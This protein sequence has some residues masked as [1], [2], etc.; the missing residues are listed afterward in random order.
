VGLSWSK[1]VLRCKSRL[2]AIARSC[3]LGRE[4]WYKKYREAKQVEEELRQVIANCED[5]CRQLE[6]KNQDL[7]DQVSDLRAKVTE[8]YQIQL[9]LGDVPSGQQYGANLIA[10]SVNLARKVGIRRTVRV[11]KIF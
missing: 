6:Q 11:L 9:P 1:F 2:S 3:F 7:C 8:P 4:H 10:L 5:R